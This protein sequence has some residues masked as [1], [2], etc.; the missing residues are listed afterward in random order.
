MFICQLK[1]LVPAN[2][3]CENEQNSLKD[4]IYNEQ[5]KVI[6]FGTFLTWTTMATW[7]LMTVTQLFQSIKASKK[8]WFDKR[9]KSEFQIRKN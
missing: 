9:Q 8:L 2:I 1:C 7:S 4:E 5:I 3:A 6:V